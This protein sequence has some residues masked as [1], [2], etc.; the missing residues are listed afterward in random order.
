[1]KYQMKPKVQKP[2]TMDDFPPLPS[3]PNTKPQ[4]PTEYL[5]R[6]NACC[7]ILGMDEWPE[8]KKLLYTKKAEKTI[9]T[10][11]LLAEAQKEVEKISR[12]DLVPGDE[13]WHKRVKEDGIRLRKAMNYRGNIHDKIRELLGEYVLSWDEMLYGPVGGGCWCSHGVEYTEYEL[14]M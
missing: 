6:Y 7:G 9:E 4:E 10:L 2:F 11:E 5:R 8:V 14:D 3:K 1:M 12:E 13:P